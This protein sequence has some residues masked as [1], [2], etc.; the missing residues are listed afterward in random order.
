MGGKCYLCKSIMEIAENIDILEYEWL[1]EE[2]GSV[3][4]AAEDSWRGLAVELNELHFV[5]GAAF[6]EQLRNIV[7]WG[8]FRLVEGETNIFSALGEQ[9][10]DF[11]NLLNAARKAVEHGYRVYILPNPKGIRTADFI[12]EQK[13]NYK[14]YD[15]KTITGK[16]SVETRLLESI[17]QTNRV[18]LNMAVNYNARLL[19]SDIK[20]YF[21]VNPDAVEV[22]IFKGK[23]ILSISRYQVQNP[24]FNRLF[25]K[26]YEK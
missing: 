24:K 7:Y 16:A 1:G 26:K 10:E 3:T 13:S 4:M 19:A 9:S 18:L 23:K 22:L 21:E 12:F 6:V 20:T 8:G 5:K 11:D 14:L 15:L 2:D 25:R 17:G